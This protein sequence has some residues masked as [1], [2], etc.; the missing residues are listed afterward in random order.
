MPKSFI[1]ENVRGLIQ[2]TSKGY[3]NKI[4]GEFK[5]AGY[6]VRV[7]DINSKDFDV[8]QSR[9]RII[10]IGIRNDL[11]VKFPKLKTHKEITFAQAVKNLNIP[12]NDLAAS[13]KAVEWP[14]IKK[15]LRYVKPGQNSCRRRH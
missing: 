5:K 7:F 8:P 6:D 10:F 9:P 15:Y 14:C 2:G 4:L 1:A 13:I 12:T 3:F 11:K